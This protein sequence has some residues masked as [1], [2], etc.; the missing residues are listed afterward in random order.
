MIASVL[1]YFSAAVLMYRFFGAMGVYCFIVFAT[2]TAN[3]EVL[4][5]VHAYGMDMTL[6]N[7]LFASTFLCTDI[8]SETQGK[9]SANKAV[10]IGLVTNVL[11]LVATQSWL[12][13]TPAAGD[14][15]AGAMRALFAASPRVI[16]SS[17]AVYAICQFFDV[18]LYHALW[19]ATGHT[20][21]YLWLRNNVATLA[22]QL[23]N[24]VLFTVF[25]FGGV[26][27]WPTIGQ[28][29]L[30]S[31][32]IFIFTSLLDTPAVYVARNTTPKR[33]AL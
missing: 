31:Y 3:I 4:M 30:S 14:L 19:K 2:I 10:A 33:E 11:F 12:L 1:V 7:V 29:I 28:I 13:Y 21:A 17:L 9:K 20:K 18:W 27:D 26:Y 6:G 32:V 8:L 23:L 22:S 16:L 5:L 25:A 24:A 15:T